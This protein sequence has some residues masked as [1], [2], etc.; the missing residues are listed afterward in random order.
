MSDRQDG[1]HVE[2]TALVVLG[3]H[4]SGTS[5]LAGTLARLG[6][7]APR[8]Q[9]GPNPENPRGFYESRPV[10]RLSDRIL[11]A[12]GSTWHDWRPLELP[13]PEAAEFRDA[14][15]AL[16]AEEFGEADR[17]VLKDPRI[18]RLV[19]IWSDALER[20]GY[21]PLPVLI[22]RAPM[23][24]AQSLRTRNG[25]PLAFGLLLWLRYVLDA[26]RL[27]RGRPREFTSYAGLLTD[28]RAVVGSL[29]ARFGLAVPTGDEAE[30][31]GFLSPELRHTALAPEEDLVHPTLADLVRG[32]HEILERWAR[33]GEDSRGHSSFDRITAELSAAAWT[34]TDVVEVARDQ[35]GR[36]SAL[37]AER[38]QLA[39]ER[40]RHLR[41]LA[42]LRAAQDRLGK[43]RDELAHL[44]RQAEKDRRTAELRYRAL[45]QS[46][47][48]RLTAPLRL[49]VGKF[50]RS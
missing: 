35:A 11:A 1:D 45:V 24:V 46:T 21:R 31:D 10:A 12:A 37:K 39:R 28:W 22:H 14:A 5:A 50:R 17:I 38:A 13:S 36:L 30:V 41:E 7:A 16:L 33:A 29:G 23:E 18:C 42:R 47:S 34:F 15:A 9:I 20:R 2:R 4:R 27:T 26:E 40:D 25:F 44:L 49:M 32:S 43:K 6:F 19:P 8:T 48:W 3:M